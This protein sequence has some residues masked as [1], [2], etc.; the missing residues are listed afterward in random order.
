MAV[1]AA[2][3]SVAAEAGSL[4]EEDSPVEVEA[5]SDEDSPVASLA[6]S[7]FSLLRKVL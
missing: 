1:A 5:A 4:A 3:T 6:A 7:N 2:S